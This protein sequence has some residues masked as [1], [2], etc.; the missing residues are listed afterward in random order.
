METLSVQIGP[1]PREQ[2]K[3]FTKPVKV[4]RVVVS[5]PPVDEDYNRVELV[6]DGETYEMSGPDAQVLG[7]MLNRAGGGDG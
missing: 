3:V 2:I 6:I 5:L 4:E 7:T 1:A